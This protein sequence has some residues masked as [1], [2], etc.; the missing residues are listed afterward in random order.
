[1][2]GMDLNNARDGYLKDVK[3]LLITICKGWRIMLLCGLL[4][5]CLLGGFKAL[6][7]SKANQSISRMKDIG[8]LIDED[9]ITMTA[10][11]YGLSITDTTLPGRYRT[12]IANFEE[13]LEKAKSNDVYLPAVISYRNVLD[14]VQTAISLGQ[15]YYD[16][17]LLVKAYASM[18]GTRSRSLFVIEG[19]DTYKARKGYEKALQ[20]YNIFLKDCDTYADLAESWGIEAK[21]I[22][23]LISVEAEVLQASDGDSTVVVS[24]GDDNESYKDYFVVNL[25][26]ENRERA[27]ELLAYMADKCKELQKTNKYVKE[28]PAVVAQTMY[29]TAYSQSRTEQYSNSRLWYAQ[30][31]AL[32][33]QYRKYV[34]ENEAAF[35]KIEEFETE[36][37]ADEAELMTEQRIGGMDFSDLKQIIKFMFIGAVLG[38]IGYAG[39]FFLYYLLTGIVLGEDEV[40][41]MY[42]LRHLVTLEN[43]EKKHRTRLDRWLQGKLMNTDFHDMDD[44]QRFDILEK[45]IRSFAGTDA[46]KFLLVGTS[47]QDPVQLIAHKLKQKMPG[48]HFDSTTMLNRSKESLDALEQCD[49]IILYVQPAGSRQKNIYTSLET[50][51]YYEK[52][53][54]G[55]IVGME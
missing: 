44:G 8:N 12:A 48:C 23:E 41:E 43:M 26:C 45:K 11:S 32:S 33:A 53:V 39:I 18:E 50:I 14:K 7:I 5:A 4:G 31:A 27:E 35:Q 38:F 1:M 25:T 21:Y 10:A 55:T 20:I 42:Q 2:V 13:L 34:S 6:R 49:G 17:S 54:I 19:E 22:A 51:Q 28:Y 15:T 29:T 24:N 9:A 47:K 16:K 40:N 52:P 36:G 37:M 3:P 46:E 30:M